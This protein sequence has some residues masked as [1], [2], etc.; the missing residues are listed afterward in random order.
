MS[1][2]ANITEFL[3]SR[4]VELAS[5]AIELSSI[6]DLKSNSNKAFTVIESMQITLAKIVDARNEAR[7][8]VRNAIKI[9]SELD[10]VKTDF[11]NKAKDL[12]VQPASIPE[13]KIIVDAQNSLDKTISELNKSIG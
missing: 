12:G 11:F 4:K 8:G 3:N 6:D 1:K 10:K 7:D 9:K 5:E 13:Y 2:T